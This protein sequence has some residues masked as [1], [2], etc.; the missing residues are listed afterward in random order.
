MPKQISLAKAYPKS[1]FNLP[2]TAI[3]KDMH[4]W[5]TNADKSIVVT[6]DTTGFE[7]AQS[8]E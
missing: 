8:E 3:I 6:N 1:F 5:F 2:K 4:V 7:V